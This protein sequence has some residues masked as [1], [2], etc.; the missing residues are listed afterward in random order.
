MTP[1]K[2]REA[3]KVL[4][5]TADGKII[6]SKEI[7]RDDWE[8][9]TPCFDFYRYDYRVKPEPLEAWLVFKSEEVIA[10]AA[11]ETEEIASKYMKEGYCMVHMREVEE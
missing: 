11:C 8:D 2:L 10:F 4:L 7:S 1:G 9:T 6:Q 5:A 3:A